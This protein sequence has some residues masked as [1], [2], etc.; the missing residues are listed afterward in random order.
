MFPAR[1]PFTRQEM[2]DSISDTHK[3][4]YGHRPSADTYARAAEWPDY[5]LRAWLRFLGCNCEWM[6]K[7]EW[8]FLQQQEQEANE[9][10]AL[11]AYDFS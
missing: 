7:A 9:W 3:S 5:Q 10:Y 2:M 4:F 8:E 6:T 1:K 11:R